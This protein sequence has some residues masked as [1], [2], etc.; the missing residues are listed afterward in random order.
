LLQKVKEKPRKDDE[1]I[2]FNGKEYRKKE[3][4]DALAAKRISQDGIAQVIPIIIEWINSDNH[5]LFVRENTVQLVLTT[6]MKK[7]ENTLGRFDP[8]SYAR[9]RSA[10]QS[11]FYPKEVEKRQRL[12]SR[13][14]GD[15]P[16]NCKQ[17]AHWKEHNCRK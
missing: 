16:I 13:I 6:I 15:A 8:R 17:Y 10:I 1:V 11:V 12:K 4:N 3:L 2:R 9:I 5:D 14:I 7:I